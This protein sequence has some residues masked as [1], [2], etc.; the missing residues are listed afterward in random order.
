[1]SK[2]R[3]LL[4]FSFNVPFDV[5]QDVQ[6][7]Y[8]TESRSLCFY[9]L[10]YSVFVLMLA[11]NFFTTI[12]LDAYQEGSKKEWLPWDITNR[13][14]IDDWAEALFPNMSEDFYQTPP[15]SDSSS[16]K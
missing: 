8:D 7:L 1:M 3:R 10:V 14:F 12:V 4:F 11:L 6:P 9:L 2:P 5:A 16:S 13:A 15:D